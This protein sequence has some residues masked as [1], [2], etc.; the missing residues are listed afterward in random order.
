MSRTFLVPTTI[1]DVDAKAEQDL[2]TVENPF[3]QFDEKRGFRAA[4]NKLVKLM[5]AWAH[6]P[7]NESKLK[8]LC[9]AVNK[10]TYGASDTASREQLAYWAGRLYKPLDEKLWKAL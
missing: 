8:K 6:D 1:P 7:F 5:L 10:D 2:Q 4:R 9:V 3:S